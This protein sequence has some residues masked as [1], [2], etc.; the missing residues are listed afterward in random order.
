[1]EYITE[2]RKLVGHRPIIMVGATILLLNSENELLL[3]HRTDNH[4]WGPPGGS[5]EL[6]ES[7][8]DC[9]KR[10][11]L[12]E[13]GISLETLNL[14]GIYSGPEMFYIYPNGDQVHVVTAVY[15]AQIN[16]NQILL[17]QEHNDFRFY[18]FNEIP[19]E[20]SHHIKIIIN[21]FVSKY[22]K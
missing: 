20:I 3:M 12:E 7:L 11:T 21:D 18:P 8:E 14:F 1:M 16:A 5:L 17:S 4:L 22:K 15:E 2:L 6:G 10:E 9:A 19:A 13:T